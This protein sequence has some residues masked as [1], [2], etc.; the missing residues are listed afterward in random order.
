MRNTKIA[1]AKKGAT[2]DL[3]WTEGAL[4]RKSSV[5]EMILAKSG[6]VDY[7][8]VSNAIKEQ[9]NRF[10]DSLHQEIVEERR[11][12]RK[13]PSTSQIK[14]R[15]QLMKAAQQPTDFYKK[16]TQHKSLANSIHAGLQELNLVPTDSL[17]S[18]ASA[19]KLPLVIS[20]HP[21]TKAI[22][23]Q[24]RT[25]EEVAMAK[26]SNAPSARTILMAAST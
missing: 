10:L 9:D 24:L 13:A 1:S 8:A 3:T 26:P 23:N 16:F 5:P 15:K 12:L 4:S 25:Q 2:G 18:Q 7:S 22:R 21:K 19:R 17:K 6:S 20:N 11:K 14:S